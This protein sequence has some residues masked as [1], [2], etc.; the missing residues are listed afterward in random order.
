M[1]YYVDDPATPFVTY[2]TADLIGLS[3]AVWPFD[4]GQSNFIIMNMAVG[5][6]WPGAPD[7]T[8]TLPAELPVAS[9]RG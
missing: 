6:D 8:T 9:G 1:V 2:T 7:G 3:G 5:G 4:A